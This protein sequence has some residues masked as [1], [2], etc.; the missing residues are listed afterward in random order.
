MEALASE[1][2]FVVRA[3]G[4]HPFG[5]ARYERMFGERMLGIHAVWGGMHA[6]RHG[7]PPYGV[8]PLAL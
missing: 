7:H 1:H 8:V 4:E 3:F 2:V 6:P 5:L